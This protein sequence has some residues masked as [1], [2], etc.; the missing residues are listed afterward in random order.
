MREG[1]E[2]KVCVCLC[3]WGSDGGFEIYNSIK[4]GDTSK[5]R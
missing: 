1:E 2:K 5:E 4:D 3:V